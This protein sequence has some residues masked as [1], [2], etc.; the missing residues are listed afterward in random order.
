MASPEW[1]HWKDAME[2]ELQ[3]IEDKGTFSHVS[4]PPGARLLT[5]KWVFAKKRDASGA[6]Q[7]YKARL[8]IRGF[9]QREGIDYKNVFAPTSTYTAWRLLMALGAGNN[10]PGYQLD[11]ETAFLYGSL[12]EELYMAT[13]AS[14][15]DL[16]PSA[17]RGTAL[18]LHKSLYGLRQAPH[19]W[20]KLISAW[21]V[22]QGFTA[23]HQ[24]PCLFI[25][26]TP[27]G[28]PHAALSI[29]V[30]D[31]SVFIITGDPA[32]YQD[33]I[34]EMNKSFTVKD[35]GQLSWYLNMKIERHDNGAIEITQPRYIEE[36]L[37]KFG[38][39][40]C[41]PT[42][43]PLRPDFKFKKASE[44][45]SSILDKKGIEL[46]GSI[47]GSVGYLANTTRP[48]IAHAIRAA[49]RVT[50]QPTEE[51]LIAVKHILRYLRGTSDQGITYNGPTASDN[52]LVAFSDSS[53]AD[54]E[55]AKSTGG[56]VIML[57]GGPIYWGSGVQSI[58]ADS[59][60]AAEY[61][62]MH[63]I[64]T[65]VLTC[66]EMMQQLGF[67]QPNGTHIFCD[68]DTSAGLARGEMTAKATRHL[69]VKYHAVKEREE[70]GS[71]RVTNIPGRCNL[72]DTFTK[73]LPQPVFT[74]LNRI[75]MGHP[76]GGALDA[77]FVNSAATGDLPV[78]G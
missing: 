22:K 24:D 65:E 70:E 45:C 75:M 16:R 50:A 48:D 35:L 71:I 47:V 66:R 54:A 10:W 63:T 46:Y 73:A 31:C 4:P 59:T 77:A 69:S 23:S 5:A 6:L 74:A 34:R 29:H 14:Y 72:A 52:T 42:K 19:V 60:A 20:N 61:I 33:F 30:D 62:Q 41:N 44:D 21:L 27:S 43:T 32:W 7:R 2:K 55:K 51:H 76:S 1:P 11:V 53:W 38:M 57:N 64:S 18:R 56:G 17:P 58:V 40:N 67:P 15:Y 39:L 37:E 8:V 36:T 3:G 78:V 49:A 28:A 12:E 26:Y 9:Q 13:P 68:N 25:R